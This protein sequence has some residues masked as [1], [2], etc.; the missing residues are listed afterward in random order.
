MT[1]KLAHNRNAVWIGPG[2]VTVPC[3]LAQELLYA[4]EA[5][6]RQADFL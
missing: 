3:R 5:Q 6:A 1:L 2:K 4:E